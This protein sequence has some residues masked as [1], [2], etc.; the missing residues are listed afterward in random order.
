M[1]NKI[2]L[3]IVDDEALICELMKPYFVR[4]GYEVII[5]TSGKQAID[6]TKAHNPQIMLL[7]NR[8]PE[9]DGVQTLE[10]IRKFNQ[11][12]KVIFISADEL[13]LEV[14]SRIKDLKITGYLRKP[15]DLEDL[16][17]IIA[18]ITI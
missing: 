16:N 2:K 14:E 1:E 11:D 4:R 7:D 12:L 13:D 9:M 5:A 18:K 10:A 15:I 8:M 6:L 3:L 17:A